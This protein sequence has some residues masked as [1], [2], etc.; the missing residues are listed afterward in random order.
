PLPHQNWQI[1]VAVGPLHGKPFADVLLQGSADIPAGDCGDPIKVNLGDIG[2]YRVEYGPKNRAALL[3]AFAQMPVDDRLNIVT[4]SWALVQAGRA[5]PSSYLALLDAL[6][7]GDHRAVW[8]QVISSFA[9]LDRLARDRDERP[10]I[11]AYARAKL[12]PVFNRLGW[13]G[14]PA[15]DD[16][17]L[18]RASLIRALGDFGDKTIRA[19]A[20]R[21]F[22]AFLV[23]ADS[24]P[25]ALRDAVTHLVG[26]T[27]DRSTHD[28]LLSLARKTTVTNER[29]RNYFAVASARDP[30]LAQAT[31]ALT[32]T[33]ELPDT[34]VPGMISAVASAGE[35]P[36]LA[37][38]FVQ[39]NFDAL[40]AKQGPNFRDQ[41]VPNF[42]TT[43]TD[44]THAAELAAFAP[45]QSTSGGRLMVARALESIAIS[46]D[47]Q[48]RVLPVVGAWIREHKP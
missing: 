9:M 31:L 6:D 36:Q 37:W 44:A 10:I 46:G 11:Q 39:K 48:A 33:S 47:L 42:M 35:Q 45:S 12:R 21:R 25:N 32:L 30:E 15:D 26:I 13:E 2:Y 41:F 7:I 27:A 16:T 38:D 20:R 8:D 19:E 28:T 40:L 4:D 23:D 22:A 1:P 5:D 24:L 3:N 34:I 18:L 29:L 17:A 43:F 14:G